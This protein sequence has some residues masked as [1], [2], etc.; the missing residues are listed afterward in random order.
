[1]TRQADQ[2]EL[3]V[4]APDPGTDIC[5]AGEW[6][7]GRVLVVAAT[8]AERANI[9]ALVQGVL[10]ADPT[11][12]LLIV[13]DD[14]PD[15]TAEAAL[16]AARHEPRLH[17]LV[18]KGRRGLGS[19]IQ[20]GLGVARGRGFAVAV[21]IDAD[22]S[23]DPADIPRLLAALDPVGGPPADVVVGSRR[24]PGGRTEGWPLFRHLTSRLV[25]LFTRCLLGVPVRDPSSGYRAIRL[26]CFNR[27]GPPSTAG[28]AFHEELLWLVSRA[29]GRI[30]EVPITFHDRTSGASKAGLREITRASRDLISLARRTWLGG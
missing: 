22:A 26:A 29:G 9:P 19:A 15:G 4:A 3:S 28:Y 18:R 21:N 7:A 11:V 10:A 23:H 14:S 8:Y 13:D 24:V 2:R 6:P 5:S 30:V 20:E 1:M 12:Q 16:A 17:V 27:L 25:G